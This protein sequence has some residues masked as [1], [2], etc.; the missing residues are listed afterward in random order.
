M[1]QMSASQPENTRAPTEEIALAKSIERRGS[2]GN[3]H[4]VSTPALASRIMRRVSLSSFG[5]LWEKRKHPRVEP[6]KVRRNVS[7][8]VDVSQTSESTYTLT[9]GRK[10][11]MWYSEDE[12]GDMQDRL[13]RVID[14]ERGVDEG[15][16]MRGL[17]M[18]FDQDRTVMSEE[19]NIIMLEH[20]GSVRKAG[21]ED[22]FDFESLGSSLSEDAIRW[23]DMQAAQDSAEAY[24]I[25]LE[26]MEPETVN[27]CFQ[28]Q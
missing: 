18:Y 16:D 5:D 8:A 27:P 15:E 1:C 2:T 21:M 9:N 11:D 12:L 23:G 26:T 14:G 3:L 10:R 25:Y 24:M 17:E 6:K 20:Y 7:F 19:C 22:S 28:S 13:M 4:E